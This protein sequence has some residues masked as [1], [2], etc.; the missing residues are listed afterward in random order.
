M[1]KQKAYFKVS[2][3]LDLSRDSDVIEYIKE[4]EKSGA[5]IS[6]ILRDGVRQSA[7]MSAKE[8]HNE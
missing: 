8:K 3:V 4:K 2:V 7:D 5:T 1:K 6:Q